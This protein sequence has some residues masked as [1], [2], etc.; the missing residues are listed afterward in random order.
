MR[1]I[2]LKPMASDKLPINTFLIYGASR[3]GKT[4]FAGTFPR[5][6][7][8]ADAS[9]KGYESLREENWNEEATPLFEPGVF[10]VVW[11]LEKESDLTDAVEAARP[12]IES[13]RILS[14]V[15]DSITFYADLALN[16]M[17]MRQSADKPRDMRKAYGDLGI[18]LRNQR[19]KVHS[20]GAIVAWLGLAA[21]PDDDHPKG[22]PM[23]PGMQSEK[24][25][26][27]VD[28]IWHSR[29]EQPQPTQPPIFNLHTRPYAKFVAG[30]RLG[31]RAQQLPEPMRGTY[32]T[33]LQSLGYDV[34]AIRAALP[35]VDL[36]KPVRPIVPKAATPPV[37]A[38]PAAVVKPAAQVSKPAVQPAAKSPVVVRPA[39]TNG[40]PV[41][42]TAKQ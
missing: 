2:D 24:F 41:T 13:G 34:D 37:A 8:L 38:K 39:G 25:A 26:A 15:V 29:T 11:A 32:T 31:G 36:T 10:P 14:I 18:Y 20:L 6:L 22:R 19:I 40:N 17:I 12:Y 35:K 21:E 5:P 4:T 3:T 7:F 16:G 1:E 27:G 33:Y 42:S 30:H 9:E 23:I 28:Y